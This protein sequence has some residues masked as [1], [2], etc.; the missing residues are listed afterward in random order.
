M[1]SS[2]DVSILFGG[3]CRLADISFA[4]AARS[5]T[6][7]V[8]FT[9]KLLPG[10]TLQM[11]TVL[12]MLAG[13]FGIT[14]IPRPIKSLSIKDLLFSYYTASQT[15][16]FVCTGDIKIENVPIEM[17]VSIS[18]SA[19]HLSF[20][21]KI[22]IDKFN[23]NLRF[24]TQDCNSN[25][26][27]ATYHPAE[28]ETSKGI[29]L[30]DLV[31]AVSESASQYIPPS[32][33]I[34]LQEVGFVFYEQGQQKQFLFSLKLSAG[35]NLKD[36]PVVGDKLPD[37]VQL[38]LRNLQFLFASRTFSEKQI[39]TL[40]ALLPGDAL[41][42]PAG[43]LAG[44]MHISGEL[45][46]MEWT[47]RLHTGN[48]ESKEKVVL[49][50]YHEPFIGK[51]DLPIGNA[52]GT[53]PV[54]PD[55]ITWFNV[56]KKLGP[57]SFQ[58]IGIAFS[59]GDLSFALDASLALGPAQFIMSGL[60]LGSSL[61]SFKPVFGL[62][63]FFMSLKTAGFELG[64]GFLKSTA[65]SVDSYYGT[66]L[67]QAGSFSFTAMGGH[68][69]S[70][71][72]PSH[73]SIQIPASFFIYAHIEIPVGGPP[74]FSVKGLAGG[75]GINNRLLLPTL[76]ELPDYILL[77]GPK[78]KA[79]KQQST[80]EA[81]IKSVL[82][83]MQKYF[84][85]ESGQYW[86]AAGISFSSFEMIEAFVV[87]TVSFGV[88][89]QIGLI[90]SCAMTLPKHTSN[91]VAYIEIA[92]LASYSQ[93]SGLLAVVGI[94]SPAS[95]LFGDF[96]RLTGGFAFYIWIDPPLVPGGP[97]AGDFLVSIGG[98]HPR[99]S[100][101]AYYPRLPRLGITFNL[102]PLQVTGEAYFAMTPSMLMAGGKLDAV[103][104]LGGVKV[105]FNLGIDFIIAWAPFTYYASGYVNIG[106]SVNLLLFTLKISI[107]V[108]IEIWGSPFGGKAEVDLGIVAFTISFG[109][110]KK[111]DPPLLTWQEFST[112]FLPAD[113]LLQ[114]NRADVAAKNKT[115]VLKG[116]ISSGLN[117]AD[118]CGLDWVIDPDCFTIRVTTFIPANQ[119]R[120][121]TAKDTFKTLPAK[122]AAYNPSSP[123]VEKSEM[124]YLAFDR[125]DTR[126]SD[127]D[128]W[129]P[130]VHI[131]PMGKNNLDSI[132]DITLFVLNAAGGYSECDVA[133]TVRPLV[134]DAAGALWNRYAGDI[135][136]DAPAFLLSA[137]TGVELSPI[138]R[139]PS[140]V[141]SV[142]LE[143][144]L[145]KQGNKYRFR[146][147]APVIDGTYQISHQTPDENTLEIALQEKGKNPRTI[148]NTE[149]IL[150][151]VNDKEINNH[152]N[153]ILQNLAATGFDVYSQADLVCFGSL[154]ALTDWPEIM[155]LGDTIVEP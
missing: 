67:A 79:P 129:N 92:I 135:Q 123:P 110:C 65:D 78:S 128:V 17:S 75:F 15:F 90:G 14:S 56:Q 5:E 25:V 39:A 4:M 21:G 44:G 146:Y 41:P 136:I 117:K 63:G 73:P 54:S 16:E 97:R 30:R 143:F 108:N 28:T 88:E 113:T 131:K 52:V 71:P 58:R 141:N 40:T 99:F 132:L 1:D 53:P 147:E 24:D 112:Q 85:V 76:Q 6:D 89:L 31:K 105:W 35:I 64:G 93:S 95:Y 83:Q 137:L 9:G 32:L 86:M 43:E 45:Q 57:V 115:N 121:G 87:A 144:L 104:K 82:P 150:S 134:E 72:D 18:K 36:I 23:F 66:V 42:L 8:V 19:S 3:I 133:L 118:V 139:M 47:I 149:Y 13:K 127:T 50:Q 153:A 29:S 48:K 142:K 38:S 59:N 100:I 7:G 98:Y 49:T 10:A 102:S 103:W 152:R 34:D 145:F 94:V 62:Q 68:I 2:G 20:A 33:V 80:P 26:F 151:A 91:P 81:T 11:G 154:T 27:V 116:V 51:A 120:I 140:M 155:K 22:T 84:L 125:F 70:H 60:T 74:Y 122:W 107:G 101:P 111:A 37:N 148:L 12:A 46:V 109:N 77:P 106:C 124:P 69:P 119:L 126:F 55:Q 130:E 96:C 61:S 114:T 138:P